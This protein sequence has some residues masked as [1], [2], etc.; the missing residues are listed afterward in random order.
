MESS[1][2]TSS[3]R[4]NLRREEERQRIQQQR[5]QQPEGIIEGNR[6]QIAIQAEDDLREPLNIPEGSQEVF[7]GGQEKNTSPMGK[8]E[9]LRKTTEE[10][11]KAQLEQP[12][13]RI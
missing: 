8:Q 3:M 2:K 4:H 6:D 12:K 9:H 5:L 1:D 11:A 10:Q 13:R 7:A